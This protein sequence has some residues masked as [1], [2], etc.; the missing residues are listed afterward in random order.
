MDEFLE[1][2]LESTQ[3]RL[4]LLESLLYNIVLDYFLDNLEV[5][6]EKIK[7]TQKNIN[8]INKLDNVNEG[9]LGRLTALGKYIINDIKKLVGLTG[10]QM[11]AYDARAVSVSEEVTKTILEH[12]NK[13]IG[14]NNNL[15]AIYAEIKQE[16][17]ALLSRY[18]GASLR[19]LR[20]MLRTKIVEKKL[21]SKYFTRWTN[22]IYSQY[23]R[24]A[25]NEIRKDLGFTWAIY[26]GGLI[27]ASRQFCVERNNRVY[28]EDEIKSWQEL[29]FKG[30]P[31][32]GY[33]PIIDCGGYNCRHR[34]DW[35]S[36]SFAKAYKNR[37][38]V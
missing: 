13:N 9:V 11:E 24:A 5:K 3:K 38:N 12:A 16:S 14:Y 22:D 23:Q 35:V 36:E 1:E 18:E 30:K 29:D 32:F 4:S 25:A 20:E 33:D 6:D 21:V 19:E 26:Q 8:A 31:Q 17:I 10:E 15:S 28:S 37:G 34:L 7:I 2:L 27:E